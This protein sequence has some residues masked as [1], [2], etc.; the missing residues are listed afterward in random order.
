MSTSECIHEI[1]Y[2]IFSFLFEGSNSIG[3][4]SY[5]FQSKMILWLGFARKFKT[6][7]KLLWVPER[8]SPPTHYH[9]AQHLAINVTLI[10]NFYFVEIFYLYQ[11]FVHIQKSFSIKF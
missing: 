5:T 6:I 1:E 3:G 4:F 8:L 2:S 10:L 7:S 9:Q 11:E